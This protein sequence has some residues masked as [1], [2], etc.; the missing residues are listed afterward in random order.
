MKK[1]LA[2]ILAALMLLSVLTACASKEAEPETEAAE[3]VEEAAETGEKA[4]EEKS[5]AGEKAADEKKEE[6]P[7]EEQK[8]EE[9]P[10]YLVGGWESGSAISGLKYY[11][12]FNEDGTGVQDANGTKKTFTYTV[13]GSKISMQYEG[14]AKP[15]DYAYTF[16]GGVLHISDPVNGDMD[17]ER[18]YEEEA[19][20]ALKDSYG[21]AE[22]QIQLAFQKWIKSAYGDD[23][24]ESKV[25]VEK[26]Y[27][28]EQEQASDALKSYNLGP[29]EVA[30]EVKYELHPAEGADVNALTAATGEFDA[31]SGWIKDKFNLGILRPDGNGGYTV[32]DVGTG[33]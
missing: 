14:E 31:D 16:K 30:F 28:T 21:E 15:T 3:A 29:D 4:A 8:S 18:F 19:P 1:I 9:S 26:I 25:Y 27:N 22:Y 5:E 13:S 11:L 32:T 7:V 10:V 2:L 24:T 23:V 6:K 20:V 17:Y 33:W 12:T